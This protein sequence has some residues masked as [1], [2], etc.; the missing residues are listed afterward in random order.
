M[1]FYVPILSKVCAVER[2]RPTIVHALEFHPQP[3]GSRRRTQDAVCGAKVRPLGA[4]TTTPGQA[5]ALHWPPYVT[6]AASLGYV[7]C[8]A[9]YAKADGRPV[10]EM[11]SVAW[12][13]ARGQKGPLP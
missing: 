3:K 2:R 4:P 6:A 8:G 13:A 9:C 12:H 11:G 7:R 1:S 10:A 5:R